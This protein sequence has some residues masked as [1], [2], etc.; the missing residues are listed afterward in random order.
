MPV[1]SKCGKDNPADATYCNSCASPLG[2][3]AVAQVPPPAQSGDLGREMEQMG[4]RIGEGFEKMGKAMG[5][6]FEKKGKDFSNWWDRT[7]GILSPVVAGT[8][9]VI[10]TVILIVVA[11][12]IATISDHRRFWE[13]LADFGLQYFLLFVG[14]AYLGAFNDYFHRRYRRQYKWFYPP[15]TGLT[16]TAWFWVLAQVLDIAASTRGHPSLADLSDFIEL[17]LPVIFVLVTAIGYLVVFV[18]DYSV[19]QLSR[20][21]GK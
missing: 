11:D 18:R 5:E 21:A 13:E 14:L 8:I 2:A 10:A 7:L 3:A 1:C 19:E 9:G 16:F 20:I 12:A 15:V 4:K 6:E 17:M